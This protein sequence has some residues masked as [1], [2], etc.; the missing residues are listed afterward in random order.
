MASGSPLSP[1]STKTPQCGTEIARPPAEA[2]PGP[3]ARP[4][5][6]GGGVKP[7]GS[8]DRI[9]FLD[10]D[11]DRA[12]AFL[13][14]H[15]EAVWVQTAGECIARLAERWDQ[16][17]L[18][19]DLGGEIFVDS[20]R[21]DCGMEV[22]RWLCSQPQEPLPNTWFFVHSHNADAGDLMVRSL[23]QHGYQAVYQPFG[24]D[25]LGWSCAPTLDEPDQPPPELIRLAPDLRGWLVRQLRRF[26]RIELPRSNANHAD[27][28]GHEH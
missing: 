8:S 20:S 19:H 22:V 26:R 7:P 18:D 13:G 11:P 6:H 15:P 12:R 14:R 2:T 9:L 1:A 23:L 27:L 10:D 3:G 17:H 4:D 21:E 24:I 16:V 5:E 28:P 25:V